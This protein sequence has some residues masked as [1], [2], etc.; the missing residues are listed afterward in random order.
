MQGA[1]GIV[2]RVGAR[3]AKQ[4]AFCVWLLL[5]ARARSIG[6]VQRGVRN[7]VEVPKHD[8]RACGYRVTKVR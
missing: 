3:G 1:P 4:L 7:I 2:Q 5:S 8:E 6:P